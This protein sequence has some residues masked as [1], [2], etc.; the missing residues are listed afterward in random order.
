MSRAR[1]R[2]STRPPTADSSFDALVEDR[3]VTVGTLRLHYRAWGRPE[4]PP[5]VVLH[6]LNSHA[7]DWDFLARALCD[8]FHVLAL[9]LHGHGESDWADDYSWEAIGA[10]VEG[11][12]RALDLGRFTL[13]GYSIGGAFAYLYAA[14]HPECVARLVVVDQGAEVEASF[15]PRLRTLIEHHC[16]LQVMDDPEQ[17]VAL[18]R[19]LGP[20]AREGSLRHTVRH[21][22]RQLDDGR[23]TW[24]DDPVSRSATRPVYQPV[25]AVRWQ[26]MARIACPTLLIRAA[27]SEIYGRATV[28]QMARTIPD[29]RYV[30]IPDSSHR[31]HWDQPEALVAT[32]RSFLTVRSD[33]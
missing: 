22:L 11:F 32:V 12:A 4:L 21:A 16:A 14:Q 17:A 23:W 20:R 6:G 31:V 30:G 26:M 28:E 24:R 15:L 1:Q 9:T 19:G 2:P 25:P 10:D 18:W 33:L 27:E 5:L 3:F 13:F 29:C 7:Y 8:R